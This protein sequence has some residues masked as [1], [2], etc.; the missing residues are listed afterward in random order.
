MEGTRGRICAGCGSMATTVEGLSRGV[1]LCRLPLSPKFPCTGR[2]RPMEGRSATRHMCSLGRTGAPLDCWASPTPTSAPPSTSSHFIPPDIL[3]NSR[4][5][6][7]PTQATTPSRLAMSETTA[8]ET[9]P[10]VSGDGAKSK[11]EAKRE[12]NPIARYDQMCAVTR[13]VNPAGH[14]VSPICFIQL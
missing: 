9:E 3:T 5:H 13:A 11:T 1:S 12:R 7:P 6:C 10:L 8:V 2:A 4:V 14:R